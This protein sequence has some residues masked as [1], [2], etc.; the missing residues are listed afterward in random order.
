[1]NPG[2]NN[3]VRLTCGLGGVNIT[4]ISIFVT[5]TSNTRLIIYGFQI[6]ALAK[7]FRTVYSV[8]DSDD[9]VKE[10]G[11]VYGLAD[12]IT[13]SDMVVNSNNKSVFDYKATQAGRTGVKFN[14]FDATQ[15][16]VMTMKFNTNN[17]EFF[18]ANIC[19]RA[20]AKLKDGAY[21]YSDCENMTIYKVSDILYSGRKMGNEE[22]HN[23]LYNSILKPINPNYK[24][25]DFNWGSA[26]AKPGE[27]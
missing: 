22:A 13:E 19:V 17:V 11:L 26:I 4:G 6:S 5:N 18:N 8:S 10:V 25:I 2:K 14:N 12:Y 21:I 20:Y 23:Y 7:G 3:T 9:K 1:M 27:L 15:S 16:Y 24:Y